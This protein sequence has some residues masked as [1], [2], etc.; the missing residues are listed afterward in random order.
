MS[1]FLTHNYHTHTVRCKHAQNTEREYIEAAIYMGMEVLGFSDHIPCPYKNGYVSPIRMDMSQA[2]EYVVTIRRL[3]REYADQI[4]ILVGFEAEYI[5]EFYEEQMALF[6]DLHMDYMIIGQHFTE[7]EDRAPYTGNPTVEEGIRTYVDSIIEGMRTG[8]YA[9][10]AH[11]DLMNYQ[12]M[13]SVYEWE[14]TRLCRAMKE[15]DIPLEINL[16]GISQK[17]HYPTERFWKIAGEVGNRVI[18]GVD[19]HSAEQL[20][21]WRSYD[22][23]ME[24]AESCG[25]QIIESLDP[26]VGAAQNVR[27]GA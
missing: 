17:K 16:N 14:M 11:P 25:L 13:D 9:Y 23:A 21:D 7:S 10:L 27:M 4:Q 8:S 1:D 2:E 5:P 18:L 15:M 12:G 3:A 20:K 19:A 6:R 26:M 22:K 24:L